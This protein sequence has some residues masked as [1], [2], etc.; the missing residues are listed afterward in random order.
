[1]CKTYG[2][3]KDKKFI[4]N[5]CNNKVELISHKNE[6][7]NNGFEEYVDVL[8]NRRRDILVKEVN[9]DDLQFA[10]KLKYKVIYN[11]IEFEPWSIGK[12]ILDK[13]K[14]SLYTSNSDL[15]SLYEFNKE[16]QFVFKKELKLS[17][18]EALIEIKIPILKFDQLKEERTRIEPNDIKKYL[19][20]TIL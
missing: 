12:H 20:D 8:G 2:I 6:D 11:S 10:Y 13:E 1:M 3:Y 17:D 4:M 16:E 9:V 15:A 5:I 19:E 14:I 18:I 7:V